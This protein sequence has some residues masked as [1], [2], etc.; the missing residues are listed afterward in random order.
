MTTLALQVL[1]QPPG[2]P[3]AAETPRTESQAPHA[4]T[5]GIPVGFGYL[6]GPYTTHMG[7]PF[8]HKY[9]P[10]THV[11]PPGEL[12]PYLCEPH[13]QC[14]G[15]CK[16]RMV[17]SGS[18]FRVVASQLVSVWRHFGFEAICCPSRTSIHKGHLGNTSLFPICFAAACETGA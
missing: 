9:I 10:A 1:A 14:A 7:S 5:V 18:R 13:A 2:Y 15:S 16:S 11:D 17:A 6:L 12:C 8:G 4:L 3:R